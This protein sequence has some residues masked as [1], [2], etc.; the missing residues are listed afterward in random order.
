[1]SNHVVQKYRTDFEPE[2]E[3][4]EHLIMS[5]QTEFQRLKVGLISNSSRMA[6][7]YVWSHEHDQHLHQL[8]SHYNAQCKFHH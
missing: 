1:M 2:I 3:P 8:S 7:W 4:I 5:K 6:G